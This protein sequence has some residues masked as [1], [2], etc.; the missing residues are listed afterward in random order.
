MTTL[1]S[2]TQSAMLGASDDSLLISA[3]RVGIAELGG[4]NP[5]AFEGGINACPKESKPQMSEQAAGLLKRLVAGEFDGLL[6][7]FLQLTAE[8]GYIVPP[9]TLPALLGL[10]KNELRKLVLPVIGERGRWLAAHNPAWAYALGRDP[11]DAWENG[12]RAERVAALEQ[13]RA[14]E[15]GKAKEWVQAAWEQ[16]APEERAAFLATFSTGLSMDDEPF[17]ETCLDDKRKEIRDAARGLLMRLEGSR[18]VGRMWARVK[19]LIQLKSKFLGGDSLEVNLPEELDPAAKRDGLGGPLLRKKLGEKANL[20]AQMLASIPPALWSKEFN[21]PPEKL[22]GLALR[23]EWKEPLL[24]G[25]QLSA[26]AAADTA[27]AE[28]IALLWATQA[29]GRSLLD[30]DALPALVMLMQVEKVEALVT[31]TIKPLIGELDDKSLLVSL[32]EKYHRPWTAKMARTVA[33]SA[34]RQ[35]G[36]LR[37]SLPQALPGFAPWMPPELTDEFSVGWAGEPKGYWRE[38]INAFLQMMNFRNEIRR[39]LKEN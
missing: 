15:P 28:A 3:A 37:I 16:D 7:E 31:S 13:I 38:K 11:F 8:R 35:S 9:E 22:V 30:L 39:S 12:L 21:R 36:E 25:W 6:P 27:W 2:L 14:G 5:V 23:C 17:L 20:L 10:G 29:A 33:Q 26:I 19:P 1:K 4:Y 18:F 34:Q 32:L 24:L